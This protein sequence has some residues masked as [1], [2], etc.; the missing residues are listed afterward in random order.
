MHSLKALLS[1]ARAEA[2]PMA[3]KQ[4]ARQNV[5]NTTSTAINREASA[6]AAP[7]HL[8]DKTLFAHA[9]KDVV[10]LIA[11]KRHRHPN[12]L[13]LPIPLARKRPADLCELDWNDHFTFEHITSFLSD[14]LPK[15]YL[16]D[17]KRGHFRPC[18]QLDL[19]GYNRRD[20]R[21]AVY[22]FID[23]AR[24]YKE[25][26]VCIIPGKGLQSF[27]GE[28][29]LKTLVKGWLAQSEHIM[30]FC[31]APASHGGSGA[32]FVLIHLPAQEPLAKYC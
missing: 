29:V 18:A 22:R 26:C 5:D 21:E 16:R 3:E 7:Q 25:Q 1:K 14:G 8:D 9:T 17:L 15:R 2:A 28:P 11:E 12:P 27:N 31:E 30:A 10:P 24:H 6:P 4:K 19:H 13:P 23:D 20:A 32:I